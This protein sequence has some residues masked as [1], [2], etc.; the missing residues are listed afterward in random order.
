M[1]VLTR[2]K[3]ETIVIDGQITIK[4]IRLSGNRVR[5]GIEAPQEVAIFRGEASQYVLERRGLQNTASH[6]PV[7]DA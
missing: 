4:V 7:I 6:L 2:K 3:E 1:L 5:L